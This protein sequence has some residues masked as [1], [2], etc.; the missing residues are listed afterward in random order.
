LNRSRLEWR[1]FH[2]IIAGVLKIRSWSQ[3]L[4]EIED[5][6]EPGRIVY[7]PNKLREIL[8]SRYRLLFDSDTSRTP[9]EISGIEP[10]TE[11]EVLSSA[12]LVSSN[13]GLAI[14]CVPD[15]I[16][17]I[18]VPGFRAKLVDLVNLIFK[19][20][21][22][23]ES[24]SCARLH[25]LNKLKSGTPSVE[26][27][28]PIM[29]S[30]PIIKLIEAIA[31]RELKDRLEPQI[32]AAQTGFISGHGTQVHML[33]LIGKILD[34]R[35]GPRFRSG[36]WFAF[37]VDFKSAFDRVD[38]IILF[39]KL[40]GS[41]VSERTIGILKLLYNSY[42]FSFL[43]DK[44]RKVN[45]GV[46]Q[47]SLVSPLLYDWY[48]NDLV[49]DL[50]RQ[51]GMDYTFAYAD[52]IALLCLGYS[53]VRQAISMIEGWGVRNGALL[54]RRKCGVLPLR[55]REATL[56]KK[57]LEGIPFVRQYKYL[58]IP[59]DS[60]LTLKHLVPLIKSKVRKFTARIG[61]ILR[62]V[63]G[64]KTK[65]DLWQTYARCHFDY[66]APAIA[67]CSQ[68]DKFQRMFTKSL[69][70]ALD[71]PIQ[72]PNLPLLHAVGIPSLV[73]IAGHHILRNKEIIIERYGR[74]PA[75]LLSLS[76]SLTPFAEGYGSIKDS[77]SLEVQPDGSIRLDLLSHGYCFER[78]V[79]GLATGTF[80]T[81]RCKDS[82]KG[83]VGSVLA[84]RVCNS[85]A[86]QI[87]F[88]NECPM[89][90]EPR[91]ILRRSIPSE[92]VVSGISGGDYHSFFCGI[93]SLEAQ[94][95]IS[96]NVEEV[97][98]NLAR[99]TAAVASSFVSRTI[100]FMSK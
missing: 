76:E 58:G 54:N 82:S 38:H 71:L 1:E 34:I 98:D 57:D 32:G 8:S 18:F 39:D 62:D 30:S 74:C 85:P 69:K 64:T 90:S 33:R 6:Q 65:L 92:F 31:L 72:L 53:E 14:D 13:K 37:F 40:R 10:S 88:L 99:A 77:D 80:L 93:R 2:K 95:T 61:L 81:L 4:L 27:L 56:P 7:E 60:A 11:D 12:R 49:L 87:H 26:D 70:K 41:G 22:I 67:L 78:D 20:G 89:N 55:L 21:R 44:P 36:N 28:R 46:A 23:P 9:F 94:S 79:L 83:T 51:F 96:L 50:S 35:E 42:H 45:S 97:V 25:L 29:I 73:Q 86:T 3:S 19:S 15:A 68:L 48:V 17:R 100:S 47:G 52:D 66:F 16:F 75:S 5:P 59:L 43:G 84:C 63:V 91:E 24:F